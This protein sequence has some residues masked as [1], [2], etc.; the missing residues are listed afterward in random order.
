MLNA[1]CFLIEV[2]M[3]K[4]VYIR[5]SSVASVN[6]CAKNLNKRELIV[7]KNEIHANLFTLFLNNFES[8]S[9]RVS[10]VTW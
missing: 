8:T 10:D 1:S 2:S 6:L 9:E 3:P 4:L 5:V 7:S